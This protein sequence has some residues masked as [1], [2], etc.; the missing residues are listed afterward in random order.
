MPYHLS[1]EQISEIESKLPPQYAA[2]KDKYPICLDNAALA[3]DLPPYPSGY[4]PKS[5]DVYY[6]EN[7]HGPAMCI[8]DGHLT[9]M[10]IED[11][12]TAPTTIMMD[13]DDETAYVQIEGRVIL[14]RIGGA[15]LPDVATNPETL[16]KS[17]LKNLPAK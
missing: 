8:E 7:A 2:L 10:E 1:P 6:D 11:P 3:W 17:I 13:I 5:I 9:Y 15:V 12:A 4:V 14:N 16:L